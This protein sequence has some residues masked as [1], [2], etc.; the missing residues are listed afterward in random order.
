MLHW[1]RGIILNQRHLLDIFWQL[2]LWGPIQI[3]SEE[4]RVSSQVRMEKG[5]DEEIQYK[6]K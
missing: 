3:I 4:Q 6:K 2:L 1:E 5:K